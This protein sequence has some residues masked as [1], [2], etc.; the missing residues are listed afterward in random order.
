[1]IL[2]G[3]KGPSL[4][5]SLDGEVTFSPDK[6]DS[7]NRDVINV[8]E[9]L[10]SGR[11]DSPCGII[12]NFELNIDQMSVLQLHA[13]YMMIVDSLPLIMAARFP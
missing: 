12:E 1:M 13:S 10:S 11:D 3:S 8:V 5:G 4:S 2:V 7:F 9:L 6:S